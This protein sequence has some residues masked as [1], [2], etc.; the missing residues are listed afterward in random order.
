M[1]A[2]VG[3][4]GRVLLMMIPPARLLLQQEEYPT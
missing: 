3:V 1:K 4:A 2:T